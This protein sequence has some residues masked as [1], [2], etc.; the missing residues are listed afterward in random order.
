M[1]IEG[2]IDLGEVVEAEDLSGCEGGF[3]GFGGAEE[4]GARESGG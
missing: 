2:G 1:P 4:L 3:G